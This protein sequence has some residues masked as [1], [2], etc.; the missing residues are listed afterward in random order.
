MHMKNFASPKE[1]VMWALSYIH[2]SNAKC[3][4]FN[5]TVEDKIVEVFKGS[6]INADAYLDRN[7]GVFIK[8]SQD[9]IERIRSYSPFVNNLCLN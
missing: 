8:I 1:A 7:R 5:I 2:C 6:D 4:L 3:V 9:G